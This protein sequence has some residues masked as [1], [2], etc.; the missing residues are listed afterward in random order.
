MKKNKNRVT[1]VRVR[2]SRKTKTGLTYES[3]I[4][5]PCTKN[6]NN[7]NYYNYLINTVI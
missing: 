4:Q 7:Y 6:N 3:K 2:V 5:K 1:K